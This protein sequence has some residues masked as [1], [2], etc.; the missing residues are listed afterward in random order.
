MRGARPA[1][2]VKQLLALENNL[3]VM[4]GHL[5]QDLGLPEASLGSSLLVVAVARGQGSALATRNALQAAVRFAV[6]VELRLGS[7]LRRPVLAL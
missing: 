4:V 3:R 1:R 5:M 6:E 2:R 7:L